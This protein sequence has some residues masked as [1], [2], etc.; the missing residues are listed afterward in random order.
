MNMVFADDEGS[1]FLDH[2][3]RG[4]KLQI[5]VGSGYCLHSQENLQVF[6]GK[7]EGNDDN[8]L[9]RLKV[10]IRQSCAILDKETVLS[11]FPGNLDTGLFSDDEVRFCSI[12]RGGDPAIRRYRKYFRALWDKGSEFP[13]R[14]IPIRYVPEEEPPRTPRHHGSESG[15]SSVPPQFCISTPT[16]PPDH[17]EG[18]TQKERHG[19]TCEGSGR[20]RPQSSNCRS[21][22]SPR[23]NTIDLD[24]NDE[25]P[26]HDGSTTDPGKARRE[27]SQ[28]CRLPL[29]SSQAQEMLASAQKGSWARNRS[30]SATPSER[31]R[32]RSRAHSPRRNLSKDIEEEC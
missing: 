24:A 18:S 1:S 29:S 23:R 25:R 30:C 3:P 17:E 12:H 31:N 2:V 21:A 6:Y 11:G 22:R 27:E 16:C 9:V 26:N 28:T 19:L 4:V 14:E 10:P 20:S 15:S 13:A 5:V 7:F 32:S 8:R